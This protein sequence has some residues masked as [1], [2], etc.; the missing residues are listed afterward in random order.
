VI[1]ANQAGDDDYDA[2][3]Q[4]QQSF[5]VAKGSQAIAFTSSPPSPAVFGGSYAPTAAGGASGN[6]VLFSI[7]LSSDPGVCSL[8]AAGTMVSFTGAGTCVIDANQAGDD[9][10]DAAA[11]VQQSFT[12]AG[13]P[14]ARIGSPAE[15]QTFALGQHVATSF[16]C[17]EGAHGPGISSCADSN[18]ASGTGGTLDTSKTGAFTYTVTATSKDGHSARAT[19]H[20]TVA[21]APLAQITSPA[22]GARYKRG[23]L[24]YASYGCQEGVSGPGLASCAG[25]VGAGQAINTSQPGQRTFTVTATSID[26]QRASM[27]VH[28]TVSL[29]SNHLKVGRL[30]VHRDGIV[31][32]DVRLPSAGRLDVLETAWND[33]LAHAAI[34]L[35]PAPRRFVFARAHKSALR[36]ETLHFRI[37][38]NARGKRLVH[39]HTYRVTLRLWVSYT[40]TGGRYRKQGFYGLYLR[41]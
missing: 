13:L 39:H 14:A 11:Q 2:A 36:A 19:I 17:T 37:T 31:T 9:D 6:P 22:G 24:V 32:F 18:G 40:P 16:S 7:D 35:Q 12:V 21:G 23:Q 27:T 5:T 1:D 26:G 38:P 3:A 4:V 28:Y 8:N 20:Y 34:L 30:R 41:K 10:Y 29:P 15:N 33:N 25:T